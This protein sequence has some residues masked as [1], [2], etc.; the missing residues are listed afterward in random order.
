MDTLARDYRRKTME[1]ETIKAQYFLN[2]NVESFGGFLEESQI[3]DCK[4]EEDFLELIEEAKE[5]YLLYVK[6]MVEHIS[7]IFN[8]PKKIGGKN[9]HS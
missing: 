5:R 6:N 8:A 4:T 2:R 7:G 1:M 3:S 9:D